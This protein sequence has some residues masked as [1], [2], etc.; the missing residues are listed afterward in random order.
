MRLLGQHVLYNKQAPLCPALQTFRRGGF[1]ENTPPPTHTHMQVCPES[2]DGWQ[3][4]SDC[5]PLR[6]E[7]QEKLCGCPR[8]CAHVACHV[9]VVV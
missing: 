7:D 1:L 6:S 3:H 9:K 4:G 8:P 2:C 5:K